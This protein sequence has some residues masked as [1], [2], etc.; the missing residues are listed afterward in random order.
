MGTLYS[1]KRSTSNVIT[2]CDGS[3]NRCDWIINHQMIKPEIDTTV[4]ISRDGQI[5]VQN[6]H[7]AV[8]MTTL[9]PGKATK[10]V[11]NRFITQESCQMGGYYVKEEYWFAY[12]MIESNSYLYITQEEVPI[13]I[14]NESSQA[15]WVHHMENGKEVQSYLPNN[16]FGQYSS[17]DLEMNTK[18]GTPITF[19]EL[20]PNGYFNIPD[21]RVIDD[22]EIFYSIAL[23][24]FV[25]RDAPKN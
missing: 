18:K 14:V 10:V 12:D 8:A 13:K 5:Y 22:L 9:E 11:C 25:I 4:S 20:Y 24:H 17:V 1:K 16:S 7:A 19:R 3:Q 21:D 15:F 6:V 23:D 2:I